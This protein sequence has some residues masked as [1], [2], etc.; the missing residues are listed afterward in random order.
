MVS[1]EDHASR[2]PLPASL[3]PR[4]RRRLPR[5]ARRPSPA[6]GP[7][8]GDGLHHR[9]RLAFPLHRLQVALAPRAPALDAGVSRLSCRALH[10]RPPPSTRSPEQRCCRGPCLLRPSPPLARRRRRPR[11]VLVRPHPHRPDRLHDVW[12]LPRD[13]VRLLA[14][15]RLLALRPRKRTVSPATRGGPHPADEHRIAA[16]PSVAALLRARLA[17]HAGGP[18]LAPAP[19]SGARDAAPRILPPPA[20]NE[21]RARAAARRAR[22]PLAHDRHSGDDARDRDGGEPAPPL[23]PCPR[24]ARPTPGDGD[25]SADRPVRTPPVGHTCG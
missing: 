22:A 11:G 13:G 25:T 12:L 16:R 21:A 8:A 18:P 7:H 20:R 14:P 10:A 19:R 24:I 4:L 23:P 17:R 6:R 5:R 15:P 9:A 1:L 3:D 2:V